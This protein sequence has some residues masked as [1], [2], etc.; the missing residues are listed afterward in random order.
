MPAA[1]F[2]LTG[3]YKI[4]QG[5]TYKLG[6]RY[7]NRDG[8]I[9]NLSNWFAKMQARYRTDAEETI[10]SVDS[11]VPNDYAN[12]GIILSDGASETPNIVIIVP[13]SQT[14]L[15]TIRKGV[16]DIVLTSPD[17]L[18]IR[19]MEGVVEIDLGVTR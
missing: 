6:L 7:K 18:A 11:H 16:Y 4:E 3:K 1:Q 12:G 15:I 5:A 10:F 8:T 19:V 13:Q 2:D 14:S 9:V 17:N